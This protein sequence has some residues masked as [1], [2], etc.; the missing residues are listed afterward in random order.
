MVKG[1]EQSCYA[2]AEVLGT[3]R[4]CR[5]QGVSTSSRRK[6]EQCENFDNGPIFYIIIIAPSGD[7]FNNARR[8]KLPCGTAGSA[9]VSPGPSTSGG[10]GS[11]YKSVDSPAGFSRV[12]ETTPAR[13]SPCARGPPPL[14]M[15]IMAF[16]PPRRVNLDLTWLFSEARKQCAEAGGHRRTGWCARVWS[17]PP[18][19]LSKE[20]GDR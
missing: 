14:H 12:V 15:A 20:S 6:S 9:M 11:M 4:P 18:P 1:T 10:G 2:Q 13:T 5:G 16:L 7:S 17:L 3:D 19:G 8:V